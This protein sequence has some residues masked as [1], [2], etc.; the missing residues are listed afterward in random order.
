MK[1]IVLIS[2]NF[3]PDKGGIAVSAYRLSI[4]LSNYY[5]I[6]IISFSQK[7]SNLLFEHSI[8]LLN[9]NLYLHRLSPF[10]N[11]WNYEL[12]PNTKAEIIKNSIIKIVE[13]IDNYKISLVHGFGLQNAGLIASRIKDIT[14]LPLIQSVRGN[15]VGRNI[16]DS[17]RRLQL[18]K[19][20]TNSN[21]IV[22]VNNW[23][24]KILINIEPNLKQKIIVI[25]NSVSFEEFVKYKINK[26]YFNYIHKKN[27]NFI[28]GYVGNLREKKGPYII[29]EILNNFIIP[30]NGRLLI[31]GDLDLIFYNQIGWKRMRFNKKYIIN[32][33]AG[34]RTEL[35][36]L[37]NYCDWLIFPSIDDG[38]ANGLIE[39]MYCG[40]TIIASTIFTDIIT[41]FKDGILVSSTSAKEYIDKCN[42]LLKNKIVLN[43]IGRN[44]NKKIRTKFSN[45][46]EL[47]HWVK[48]YNLL[49][50]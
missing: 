45:L 38:M 46:K 41:N 36:N 32:I 22:T 15:D 43:K 13:I 33:N 27:T 6:H 48:E 50:N 23:L 10:L 11:G 5:K 39:S 25:P 40:K 31:I 35:F 28:I 2:E 12:D 3:L 14:N 49:L 42:Y 9:Q 24:S 44:A 21:I 29:K 30:N 37:I 19:A 7:P 17:N 1:N 34:S 8:I 4:L 20:L 18:I 26:N 47:N 16:Y